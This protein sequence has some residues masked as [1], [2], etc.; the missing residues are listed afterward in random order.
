MKKTK[1]IIAL[2]VVFTL[3]SFLPV[4]ISYSK[5]P[6]LTFR[7]FARL[8]P[9]QDLREIG[10]LMVEKLFEAYQT[11]DAST[12]IKLCDQNFTNPQGYRIQDLPLGLN[13]VSQLTTNIRLKL[14]AINDVI[15]DR[16]EKEI[17]LTV[18]YNWTRSLTEADTGVVIKTIGTNSTAVIVLRPEYTGVKTKTAS[19]GFGF[20][21]EAYAD[22]VQDALDQLGVGRGQKHA[23]EI[24]ISSGSQASQT[25]ASSTVTP[26]KGP[27]TSVPP[28]PENVFDENMSESDMWKLVATILF[29][30]GDPP[31]D[32][33]N[34]DPNQLNDAGTVF[35]YHGVQT[36]GEPALDISGTSNRPDLNGNNYNG[37][38][39]TWYRLTGNPAFSPNINTY[40]RFTWPNGTEID[41]QSDNGLIT[42]GASGSEVTF[43]A[44]NTTL[45]VGAGTGTAARVGNTTQSLQ[46]IDTTSFGKGNVIGAAST[47]SV[48]DVFR[49]ELRPIGVPFGVSVYLR[50]MSVRGSDAEIEVATVNEGVRNLRFS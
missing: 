28:P 29:I 26:E 31:T 41:Y 24:T 13:V 16:G 19:L 45:L 17:R 21:K 42:I 30:A 48:G 46:H 27:Q 37:N 43:K 8:A 6:S 7:E 49:F 5:S 35:P 3:I 20:V 1:K 50:I 36:A 2:A 15:I 18:E 40:F 39:N 11:N 4:E 32:A 38:P 33:V 22:Q 47:F 14:E 12:F 44:A 10:R 25:T 34:I 9:E 23:E